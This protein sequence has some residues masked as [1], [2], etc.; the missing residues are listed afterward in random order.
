HT[1]DGRVWEERGEPVFD[2]MGN[3]IGVVEIAT[4]ITERKQAE[5][6]LSE[7]N[8]YLENL[9]NYA[10]A[11]IIV[12]DPQFR[13]TR[14]NHAFE[15]L[16]GLTEKD[17]LG[18]SIEILFPPALA[19]NS[20]QLI[21]NTLTGERWVTVEIQ[22]RHNDNSV[23][24]VLWNS[25]TL[26]TSDGN[27]IATIAQGQDIT[28]RKQAEESL[29]YRE[30]QFRNLFVNAPVGI[31]HSNWNGQFL[32]ANPALAK[33]LGYSA[34]EE[35]ILATTNMTTQIYE[36]PAIRPQIMDALWKTD[37]WV[38]YD[39]IKWKSIDNS[40]IIVDMTG[41]KVLDS[42]G[43]VDYLEGFIED[44]TER[45]QAEAEIKRKNEE[46]VLLNAAKDKFF[47]IISH[48]LRSPFSAFLGL[49][50]VMVDDLPS[51]RLDEI[52][53]IALAMRNSATN[54]FRFLENL[55][56]WSRMEQ[57]L[58]PFNP[59]TQRLLPIVN[60]SLKMVMEPAKTKGIEISLN[61]PEELEIFADINLLQ[62][63]IRNLVSNAVKFTTKG[64]SVSVSAKA[65]DNNSVELS[66]RDTGIGMN[67]EMIADLFRLDVQT[68]R[69]GTEN[70]PSSGL[71]LLLCK[72]FV[73][74]HG[75]K[76]WVE[77]EEGKGS[78]FYFSLPIIR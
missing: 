31:F 66:I 45:K 41:R 52:Q 62:T 1:P 72:D 56:D 38:H 64:G 14:F 54:L 20:M 36:D 60:E 6:M 48:D 73:E 32:R 17:V 23:K 63:V 5:K 22:I 77:S 18:Q 39:E 44:I 3:V 47:S 65:S 29:K 28:M 33:M 74:K 34:P 30:E 40:I 25:A 4:D 69:R 11:P 27:T 76:L 70:E 68:N 43:N 9:I 71:G 15:H 49:T 8:A 21:H 13:I 26:F 75:G 61:I 78:T 57:G 37:G 2:D 46:L 12:W 35:L 51:M 58:I 59:E 55:L 50:R 10:N 19:E 7:T 24:T 67:P 16:T 42:K 53:K